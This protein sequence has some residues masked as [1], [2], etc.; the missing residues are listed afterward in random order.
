[1]IFSSQQPLTQS[2]ILIFNKELTL[3]QVK[4]RIFKFF[5]PVIFSPPVANMPER[6]GPGYNEDSVLEAEY[7][8]F[9]E[10]GRIEYD[11][12][13]IG[14]DLYKLQVFNNTTQVPG[15]IFNYRKKCELC[16]REH[17]DNCDFAVNDDRSKLKHV[18]T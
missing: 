18:I 5:R 17:K 13:G 4:K 6:G 9:F 7:K 16:D 12:E 10:D 15:M 11:S 1:M 2:R 3:R 14:N 8:A